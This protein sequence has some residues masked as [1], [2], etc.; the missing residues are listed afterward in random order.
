MDE[1]LD[2]MRSSE[3]YAIQEFVNILDKCANS[4][5]FRNVITNR[6]NQI[7][8]ATLNYPIFSGSTSGLIRHSFLPDG[9]KISIYNKNDAALYKTLVNKDGKLTLTIADEGVDMSVNYTFTCA[10]LPILGRKVRNVKRV[11]DSEPVL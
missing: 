7:Y 2:A 10:K 4:D 9:E 8:S 5:S 6:K 1:I 3:I 11:E